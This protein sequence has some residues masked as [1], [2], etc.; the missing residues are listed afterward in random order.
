MTREKDQ[1]LEELSNINASR[2]RR[3]LDARKTIINENQP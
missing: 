1:S 2:Y 3:D